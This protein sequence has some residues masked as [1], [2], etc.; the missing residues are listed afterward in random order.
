[1][2]KTLFSKDLPPCDIANLLAESYL[3]SH[4]G[5]FMFMYRVEF[6][7]IFRQFPVNI[8]MLSWRQKQWLASA[9]TI[10]P[11]HPR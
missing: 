9:P 4:Q 11:E 10:G 7:D 1:M 5:A 8:L 6:L 2:E 3:H